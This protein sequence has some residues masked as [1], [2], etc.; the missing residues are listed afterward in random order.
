MKGILTVTLL[1]LLS[2]SIQAQLI[3]LNAL[4]K[5][6]IDVAEIEKELIINGFTKVTASPDSNTDTYAYNYDET[7]EAASIRVIIA[8]VIEFENGG[9]YD[10]SVLTSGDYIHD[11]LMEEI[12]E[13]CTFD[14]LEVGDALVY[15]CDYTTFAVSSEGG[16][17]TITAFPNFKQ[18][19]IDSPVMDGLIELLKES[20]TEEELEEFIQAI[21]EAGEKNQKSIE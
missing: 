14:G 19:T 16:K 13:N 3:T 8:P 5:G 20:M 11:E 6:V 2:V 15:T 10:I 12:S 17:N 7:E 9:L 21:E 18:L 1:I 4:K